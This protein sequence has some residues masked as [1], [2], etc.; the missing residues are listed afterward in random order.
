MPNVLVWLSFAI[1]MLISYLRVVVA[2]F[3][4]VYTDAKHQPSNGPK[5]H[6]VVYLGMVRTIERVSYL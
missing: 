4:S 3:P 1:R 5:V 2:G 6:S